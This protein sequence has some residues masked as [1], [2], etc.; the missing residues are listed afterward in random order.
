MRDEADAETTVK[1]LVT[2]GFFEGGRHTAGM[3]SG[4]LMTPGEQYLRRIEREEAAVRAQGPRWKQYAR[5]V[6]FDVATLTY[7]LVLGL[8]VGALLGFVISSVLQVGS[9]LAAAVAGGVG[10]AIGGGIGTKK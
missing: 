5:K 6:T 2:L 7:R 8:V 4:R 1:R 3:F 9:V 10:G